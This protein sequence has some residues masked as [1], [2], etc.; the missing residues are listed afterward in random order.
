MDVLT[1]NLVCFDVTMD[2]PQGVVVAG[3]R[4]AYFSH[5]CPNKETANEDAFGVLPIGERSAILAVAD[6]NFLGVAGLY[7]Y[8]RRQ[9]G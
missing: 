1:E 2:A 5:R 3:G 9:K 6:R 8:R 7:I 4:A